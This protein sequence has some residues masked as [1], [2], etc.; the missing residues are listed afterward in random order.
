MLVHRPHRQPGSGEGDDGEHAQLGAGE[1]EVAATHP[2]VDRGVGNP[3]DVGEAGGGPEAAP[4]PLH[5]HGDAHGQRGHRAREAQQAGPGL[6]ERQRGHH[7]TTTAR[8]ASTAALG[9][10]GARAWKRGG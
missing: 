7:C 8:A 4:P 2:P 3:V 10:P 1:H 6:G 9:W 5:R